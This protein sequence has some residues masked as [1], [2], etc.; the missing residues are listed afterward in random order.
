ML[1][2][3]A[4][5]WF[6]P[7]RVRA[8]GSAAERRA[9]LAVG[10]AALTTLPFLWATIYQGA[11]GIPALGA[12]S[13]TAAGVLAALPF[14]IRA[15]GATALIAHVVPFV[16][17]SF[18]VGVALATQGEATGVLVGAP[19]VPLAAV[20]LGGTGA[21]VL[22]VAVTC[23]GLVG[24]IVAVGSG[25]PALWEP[26]MVDTLAGVRAA[27]LAAM[28]TFGIAAIYESLHARA[29]R[30]VNEAHESANAAQRRRLESE[31]R[32]RTLTENASDVIAE[33]DATGSILY[34][35]PQLQAQVGVD[36]A[37]VVGTHW[38]EHVGRVHPQDLAGVE[39][40]FASVVK[41]ER[42]TDVALRFRHG[43]DSWRWIEL[44]IRPFRT[45]K[46]E[47]RMVS[48]ARDVTER[49]E[50]ETLRRLTRELEETAAELAR[51]NRELEEFTSLASHDLQEPLR[52]L[53]TFSKLLRDDLGAT[54]PEDAE[55]DLDF[56]DQGARRMHTLVQDLL[57]LSRTGVSEMKT[58]RIP[59]ELC[60]DRALERL[61]LRIE[62]TGAAIERDSLPEL[63]A[64][65]TLLTEIFQN[66]IGN[67]LK[68]RR[69][70]PP[71]IRVTAERQRGRWTIG[72]SDNGIG[73]AVDDSA[74]I[75]EPFRR[76]HASAG[77][78]GSGIGLAICRKAVERHG[79][80]IWVESEPGRGAHFRFTLGDGR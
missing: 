44:T 27:I 10:S 17:S 4:I 16:L 24:V 50:V 54:L 6:V 22:W 61:A 26:A 60:L 69:E 77:P 34:V 19:V 31:T 1:W 32:F 71:R 20:L 3:R 64:D 14:A 56:I 80:R 58:E 74:V 8:R 55:R 23:A 21:G 79:G 78:D 57:T 40:M 30:D 59:S 29:L 70:A 49:R 35:S 9:R 25:L 36:P 52:K 11:L 72:V 37:T 18:C 67:A 7:D 65:P 53:V 47:L 41:Y 13:G 73:L 48:V 42:E 2:L 28:G 33:W 5:D 63:R 43:D 39:T 38:L 66:L 46:G 51:A 62:E 45:A 76:L 75:F 15:T 12:A 68:F